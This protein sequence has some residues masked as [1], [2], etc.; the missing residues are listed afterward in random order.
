[1]QQLKRLIL[2]LMVIAI[3]CSPKHHPLVFEEISYTPTEEDKKFKSFWFTLIDS[4]KQSQVH[5][6]S[7]VSFDSLWACQSLYSTREFFQNCYPKIFNKQRLAD[8]S[9]TS[10]ITFTWTE[11]DKNNLPTDAQS[12]IIKNGRFYQFEQVQI[13][14]LKKGVVHIYLSVDFIKTVNGYKFYGVDFRTRRK[15]CR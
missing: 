5:S 8:L 6:L 1:M 3:S 9:D 11:A 7:E 13:S 4:L 15:C 14:K 12:K 2:F 10:K